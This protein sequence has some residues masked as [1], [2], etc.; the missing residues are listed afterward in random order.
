MSFNLNMATDN[1]YMMTP[2]EQNLEPCRIFRRVAVKCG[3]TRNRPCVCARYKLFGAKTDG[4]H[5]GS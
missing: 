3:Q 4:T 2:S 1:M 5:G